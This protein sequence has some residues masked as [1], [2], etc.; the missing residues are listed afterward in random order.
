MNGENGRAKG[1]KKRK[2]EGGKEEGR[3]DENSKKRNMKRQ[4]CGNNE[5]N[6]T[7]GT[8]GAGTLYIAIVGE[9]RGRSP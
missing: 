2:R 1:K 8:Q 5:N 4:G 7:W 6:D 3:R 9:H